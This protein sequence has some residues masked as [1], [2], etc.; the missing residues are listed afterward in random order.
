M[1]G[2]FLIIFPS[3]F[4]S[5]ANVQG[6]TASADEGGRGLGNAACAVAARARRRRPRQERHK[7]SPGLCDTCHVPPAPAQRVRASAHM[8]KNPAASRSPCLLPFSQAPPHWPG[9]A[10]LPPGSRQWSAV[11]VGTTP[12]LNHDCP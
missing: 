2:N 5:N 7:F 11:P 8:W 3:H 12:G 10:I 6:N 1:I 9:K 4:C